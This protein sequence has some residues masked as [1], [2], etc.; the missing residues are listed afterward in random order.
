[1]RIE[2]NGLHLDYREEGSGVPL[3]L[4]HGYPLSAAIWHAQLEGLRDTAH[5]V[6]P[7]LRGFGDS[8]AS[9]GIYT[10]DLLAEDCAALLDALGVTQ[11]AVIGGISMGG[12]VAFAF[13][14]KYPARVAGL[15]LTGTRAIPDSP[16]GKLNRER[17][18]DLAQREGSTAIARAMLPKMFAPGIYAGRPELPRQLREVME[19]ASVNGI[20]GALL[21][22]RDRPDSTP[23]LAQITCP[24]LILHGAED[25]LI[26]LAEA[27]AMSAAIHGARLAVIP[28]AG[29]MPQLEQPELYNQ[30]MRAFLHSH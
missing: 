27:E 5:M 16:D 21:G 8:Q 12:Y 24:T 4:I 10:M 3:L 2:V 6:T 30:A 22:M 28:N 25:Q 20:V 23:T 1:M 13:Y 9:E 14:R 11:P 19:K 26:P 18:A 15:I 29:H 17:T 7:D